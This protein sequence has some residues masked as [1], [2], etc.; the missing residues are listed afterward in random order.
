MERPGTLE[1]PG[2]SSGGGGRG[3]QEEEGR[4]RRILQEIKQPHLEGWGMQHHH[5]HM[6]K[7]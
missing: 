1:G 7:S 4:T 2:G 3:R 6:M 5:G